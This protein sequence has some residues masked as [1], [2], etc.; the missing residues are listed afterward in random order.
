VVIVESRLSDGAKRHRSQAGFKGVY[1]IR[2]HLGLAAIQSERQPDMVR[3]GLNCGLRARVQVRVSADRQ[4][5]RHA[6]RNGARHDL[7]GIFAAPVRVRVGIRGEYPRQR[8]YH[9]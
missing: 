9:V 1:A 2:R 6:R 7:R 3:C 8:G 4:D 5:T